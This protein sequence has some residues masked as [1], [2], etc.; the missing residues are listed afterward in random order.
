MQLNAKIKFLIVG[1]FA[2]LVDASVY[3]ILTGELQLSPLNARMLAFTIAVL[4]TCTGNRFITFANR[5]HQLFYKQY[6]LALLAGL[7]SLLPNL[8][9]FLGLLS[10][11]P[12][13]IIFE[14]IAFMCGTIAGIISNY[15]LSDKLIFAEDTLT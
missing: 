9:V 8:I 14:L 1:G 15:V 6:A 5:N 13:S 12:K 3:L 10:V 4:V 7:F 2:F 11:L